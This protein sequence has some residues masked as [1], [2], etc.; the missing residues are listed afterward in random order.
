MATS[1]TVED[2]LKEKR[3]DY[4]R[5]MERVREREENLKRDRQALQERL[6][7]FYKYI[8]DNEIKRLRATKKANAEEAAKK[9]R[10][11]TIGRLA[12]QMEGLEHEKHAARERY[13]KYSKYER[14]LNDVLHDN[15]GEEY[16]EA[17]DII[18]RY[19][20]LDENR[21]VLKKRKTQLERLLAESK[22]Q[23]S[24]QQQRSKNEAVD[25]QNQVNEQQNTLE[26]L[27]RTYKRKQDQLE[28]SITHK[29]STT[30]TIGQVR[31]A[32][33]NLYDC[34]QRMNRD[35]NVRVAREDAQDDMLAQLQFI[36]DCLGDY[37]FVIQEWRRRGR[38]AAGGAPLPANAGPL[39]KDDLVPGAS[40]RR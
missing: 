7:Q 32:C 13:L 30:K 37:F 4:K 26:A 5:R 39:G 12:K 35:N 6:V 27:Q 21:N 34:C 3:A 17:R 20:T 1:T 29:S 11:E 31:M 24:V 2:E 18:S 15:D 10:F 19:R 22:V 36:G 8:Q 38:A 14:Y 33:Q 16:L 9:E 40:V 23:L 25:L 28:H